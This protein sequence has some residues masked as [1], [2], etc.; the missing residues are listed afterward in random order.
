M[1]HRVVI[2]SLNKY[3][4]STYGMFSVR[5]REAGM[6]TGIVTALEGLIMKCYKKGVSLW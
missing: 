3:F 4:L 6:N 5:S 2:Y 1:E